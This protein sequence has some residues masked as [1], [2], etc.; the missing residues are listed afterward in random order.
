MKKI[1]FY[2]TISILW[3]SCTET[4]NKTPNATNS[5][6]NSENIQIQNKDSISPINIPLNL[7]L[8][9]KVTVNKIKNQNLL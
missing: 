7:D 6:I 5:I 8:L 9:K 3:V 1:I 4:S 2:I